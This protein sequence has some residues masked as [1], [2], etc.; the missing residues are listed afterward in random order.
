MPDWDTD[1]PQ[2]RRNLAKL[3]R[4]IRDEA[5][6]RRDP[7]LESPRRWHR[8]AMRG[9]SA[10]DP[11]MIG[12]FRG[13]DGLEDVEVQVGMQPGVLSAGVA[14]ALFEFERTLKRVVAR[15]D[16]LI[17]AGADLDADQL[18]A[19]IDVCAWGHAEWM[20]IHPFANGNGRTARLWANSLAM[21]YGLPPFVRLRPRPDGSYGDAGESAMRGDWGPTRKVFHEMLD[22]A[23]SGP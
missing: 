20:R 4:R 3:L 10:P 14:A 5:R 11:A 1:S 22:E 16:E 21:R 12:K 9:L 6:Q 15:L 18:A 7:D 19:V 2:L 13:E 17:P 8:E 23:L